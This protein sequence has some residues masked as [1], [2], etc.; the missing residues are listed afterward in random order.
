LG[1]FKD[2]IVFPESPLALPNG[3]KVKIEIVDQE[4]TEEIS[5][6]ISDMKTLAGTATGYLLI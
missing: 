5:H 2:G 4:K 6:L 3:T 1:V